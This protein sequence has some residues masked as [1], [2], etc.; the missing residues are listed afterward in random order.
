MCVD[1]VG[2]DMVDPDDRYERYRERLNTAVETGE[3]TTA[4]HERIITFVNAY[5]DKRFSVPTPSDDTSKAALTLRN[6]LM[7]LRVAARRI[8]HLD[9][10]LTKATVSEVNRLMSMYATGTHPD[11]KS[12][13]L[14]NGTVSTKQGILRKFYRYHDALGVD[15]TAIQMVTQEP[16]KIT[17]DDILTR[18]QIHDLLNATLNDRDRAM[19][20]LFAYTGQRRR[21]I[22]TLRIKDVC[23]GPHNRWFRLNS[24]ADGLKGAS[25]KRPLL[26]ARKPV[27]TWVNRHPTGDPEDYLITPLPQFAPDKRLGRQL[28]DSVFNNQLQKISRRAGIDTKLTTHIFRHTFVTLAKREY[29]LDD[30]HIKRLIGHSDGSRVMETTYS[31]LTDE[32]SIH[33]IEEAA[34]IVD[35]EDQSPLTPPACPTCAEP[36]RDTDKAC[37]NCGE[38]FTPDARSIRRQIEHDSQKTAY[39]ISPDNNDQQDAVEQFTTFLRENPSVAELLDDQ[40]SDQQ[41]QDQ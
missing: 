21:A 40:Q 32:D 12:D 30:A 19:V 14:V 5:D 34:G 2:T 10:T 39:K 25:G 37:S 13:G 24:T 31:H 28:H 8:R 3:I 29:G 36:L 17:A 20:A 33:A 26:G 22:Q 41:Q 1:C 7:T 35:S 6:Y 18:D 27:S 9:T 4:D 15:A 16:T 38:V 23:I 11:V